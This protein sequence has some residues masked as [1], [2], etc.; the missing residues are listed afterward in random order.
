MD[1]I[2]HIVQFLLIFAK[3]FY[4]QGIVKLVF[5]MQVLLAPVMVT[6]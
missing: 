4:S 6:L 2:H 3:Q 1:T 5:S